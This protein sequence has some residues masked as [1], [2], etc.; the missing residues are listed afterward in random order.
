MSVIEKLSTIS[1]LIDNLFDFVAKDAE[2]SKDFENHLLSL[3]YEINDQNQLNSVLLPYI[4]DNSEVIEKFIFKYPNLENYEKEI[5]NSLKDS[6]FGV[7]KVKRVLKNGFEVES[8]VNEKNYNLISLVKMH[9]FRGIGA[10]DYLSARIFKLDNEYYLLEISDVISSNY[11]ENAERLAISM[12]IKNPEKLFWDNHQKLETLEATVKSLHEKFTECFSSNVVITTNKHAD[13]LINAFN[14]FCETGVRAENINSLIE[15]I[16]EYKFFQIKDFET[17]RNNFL[18]KAVEGFSSHSENYDVAL[19]FDENLGLFVI[20]FYQT[21]MKIFEGAD[22]Q[23][24]DE[25]VEHFVKSDKV[26][27]SV[28]ALAKEKFV[29][30]SQRTAQVL[31]EDYSHEKFKPRF[32]KNKIFS[33]TTALFASKTFARVMGYVEKNISA[34]NF[35]AMQI[36][37]NDSCPC[38]S[39]LKYKKCCMK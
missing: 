7:F 17:D 21:F 3:G 32:L 9:N 4:L 38:G 19:F 5:L 2:I 18:E 37:R 34:Q 35:D 16:K 26:P 24:A 15:D 25:C 8:I 12:Q 27:P 39:G 22:V 1:S 11:G 30:F 36:G 10:C 13:E 6:F 20:P 14:D 29:N 31:K 28:I 23:N 33:S